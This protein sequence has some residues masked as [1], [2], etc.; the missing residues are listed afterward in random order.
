MSCPNYSQHCN[1]LQKNYIILCNL[2]KRIYGLGEYH[3]QCMREQ[4]Y[5][6]IGVT[7]FTLDWTQRRNRKSNTG[8]I[9]LLTIHLLSN[10]LCPFTMPFQAYF[11]QSYRGQGL[12]LHNGSICIETQLMPTESLGSDLQIKGGHFTS[13]FLYAVICITKCQHAPKCFFFNLFEST[14]PGHPSVN[15]CPT[16]LE[17][18]TIWSQ[19]NFTCVFISKWRSGNRKSVDLHGW[20]FKV[21]TL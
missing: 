5:N 12:Y 13:L 20:P 8:I 9:Y 10:G 18:L 11:R 1:D 14:F 21:T 2:E 7:H 3:E 16:V 15:N 19:W 17:K 4:S 6:A